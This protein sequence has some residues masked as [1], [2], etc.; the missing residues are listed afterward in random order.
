MKRVFTTACLA[1]GLAWAAVA[2]AQSQAGQTSRSTTQ[3]RSNANA[4]VTLVGCLQPGASAN[5]YT[6]KV[7]E[8]PGARTSRIVQLIGS[9]IGPH[10]GHTVEVTGTIAPRGTGRAEAQSRFNV[11]SIRMLSTACETSETTGTV[12]DPRVPVPHTTGTTGSTSSVAPR[13][14]E[15][16]LTAA[17]STWIGC[18][19]NGTTPNTFVLLTGTE[20]PSRVQLTAESRMNLSAHSGHQVEITGI[21][22]PQGTTGRPAQTGDMKITVTNVRMIVDKCST[23]DPGIT[24]TA[25]SVEAA[26]T[27]SN[28]GTTRPK[29]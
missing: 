25:G 5:T 20:A 1:A 15:P 17:T 9:N 10:A 24:G 2:G 11:R 26:P 29:Y 23:R 12:S 7:V 28:E 8:D 3:T 27:D 18:V 19:E 22:M 4:T 6:L 13:R 21:L 14:S 16:D